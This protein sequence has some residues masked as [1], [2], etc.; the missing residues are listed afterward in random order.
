MCVS[1][2]KVQSLLVH[3]KDHLL[4][5]IFNFCQHRAHFLLALSYAFYF[6]KLK[7]QPILSEL[8]AVMVMCGLK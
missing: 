8:L 1:K 4:G 7:K 6:L 2:V 3:S 5:Q